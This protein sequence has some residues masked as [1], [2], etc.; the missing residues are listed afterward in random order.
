M[1]FDPNFDR[2]TA[3]CASEAAAVFGISTHVH[4]RAVFLE[5]LGAL[6]ADDEGNEYTVAGNRYEPLILERFAEA[7]QPSD[8]QPKPLGALETNLATMRGKA[9]PWLAATPD[10]RWGTHGIEVKTVWSKKSKARWEGGACP[11]EYRL[12]TLHQQAVTDWPR[13]LLVGAIFEADHPDDVRGLVPEFR[14][15]IRQVTYPPAMRK[16]YAAIVGRWWLRH[17]VGEEQPERLWA[18]GERVGQTVEGVLDRYGREYLQR[19]DDIDAELGDI[20]AEWLI[21]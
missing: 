8:D 15:E 2:K 4:P 5:K 9:F 7:L 13:W 19:H 20:V 18:R 14:T 16:K 1:T 10:G 21:A 12:Q 17:V 6:G 3:V 11:L